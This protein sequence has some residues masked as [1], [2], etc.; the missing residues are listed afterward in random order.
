MRSRFFRRMGCLLVLFNLL[1]AILFTL[2]IALVAYSLGLIR[3][4][5]GFSWGIALAGIVFVVGLVFLAW[6]SLRLRRTSTPLGDLLAAS[7]RVAEGDYSARVTEQGLPE[8]RSLARAFNTMASRLQITAEQRRNLMAD[9]THELRTPLTVIQGNLE[10]MLDGVYPADEEHLKSILE[11]TQLLS[12]LVDDLRT[13]ALAESGALQLRKEPADLNAL[14]TD[15]LAAFRAQADAAGVTLRIT[16]PPDLP[17][18]E[19]DPERMH[20]VLSNLIANALRYTPRQGTIQVRLEL[21]STKDERRAII[22]IQDDG[23]GIAA[24]DLPHVFDRF[25]KAQDSGGMGLGL[26]IAKHLVE[27]HGGIL[28]A[29]SSPGQGTTMRITLPVASW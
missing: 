22:T 14:I 2:V 6:A 11:E 27:A 7:E 9:V 24:Q 17:L 8:V 4:P 21:T 29:E 3:M 25:Y 12:R 18:L 1:V 26:S 19:I 10:G 28:Q 16:V 13:L 23:P 5:G 15:T 20:Q